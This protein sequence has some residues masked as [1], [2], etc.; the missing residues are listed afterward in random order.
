MSVR[1]RG[2]R[3][4]LAGRAAVSDVDLD[5]P[6]GE[7]FGLVGP[8]GSGKTTLLRALYRA[9]RPVSGSA[10]VAGAPVAN[11]G[12]RALARLL[13]ATT[14]EVVRAGG[15]AV[16]EV[17]A[18][19]RTAHLGLLSRPGPEDEDAVR[20][21][22]RATELAGAA[23]RDV[24]RLSGGELQRVVI[25][26]A[27]AQRP[28]VL[29]LDEPTN[30][31]DLRHR[32]AV[33]QLLGELARGGTTVLLTAHDLDLA[34]RFCDRLGVLDG[35]RLVAAGEPG[36]V[37]DER[38]LAEVFGIRARTERAGGRWRLE[39]DGPLD[40]QSSDHSCTG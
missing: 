26:R 5:V 28:Q 34:V 30:H 2:L 1:I 9:V 27:L 11:T 16:R 39:V 25:A 40:A 36:E 13:G 23:D 15:L 4:E 19:G 3:V 14:Q 35:G 33:L 6:A 7:V 17:V 32:Y 24:S 21:A 29:V 38:L 31:L 8:N 37:L 12:R 18:Q 20:R 10:D 22:L